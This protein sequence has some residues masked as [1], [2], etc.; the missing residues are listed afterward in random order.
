MPDTERSFLEGIPWAIAVVGW[1]CTHLFSEARERRKEVRSQLDKAY[2]Q[3][4]KLEQDSRSFHCAEKFDSVKSGDLTTRIFTFERTLQRIKI[5]RTDSLNP[6]IIALRR[7]VT[8]ENF[9]LSSFQPQQQTSPLLL[10]IS[11]AAEDLE[12]A[13][14]HRYSCRY[15]NHFPYF[16]FRDPN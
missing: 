12:Q 5:V 11:A 10:E 4:Q 13:L 1:A 16:T 6:Y 8:L 2:E 14:E 7:A 3:L 15:P 9:E